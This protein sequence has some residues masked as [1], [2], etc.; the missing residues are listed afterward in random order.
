MDFKN[1]VYFASLMIGYVTRCKRSDC[2][3][4]RSV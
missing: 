2:S 3:R 1:A 4:Y